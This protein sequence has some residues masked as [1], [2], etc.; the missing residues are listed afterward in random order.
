MSRLTKKLK[1]DSTENT[2]TEIRVH[3]D[4][5]DDTFAEKHY[6]FY[7]MTEKNTY[8]SK[9]YNP[10]Y[11]F[12]SKHKI[13]Y[14]KKIN[15]RYT[16][17]QEK[18][19]DNLLNEIEYIDFVKSCIENIFKHRKSRSETISILKG[20]YVYVKYLKENKIKISSIYEIES[21]QVLKMYRKFSVKKN[22]IVEDIRCTDRFF[23]E[24][25]IINKKFERLLTASNIVDTN[26]LSI[27]ALSSSVLYQLKHCATIEFESIKKEVLEKRKW[28]HDKDTLF[29]KKNLLY[30]YIKSYRKQIKGQVNLS[31]IILKKLLI[32]YNIDLY[33]A[34]FTVDF[35]NNLIQM[36]NLDASCID[37]SEKS[38]KNAL[39]WF[40]EFVPEYPHSKDISFKYNDFFNGIF[41]HLRRWLSRCFEI[42]TDKLD[43]GLFPTYVSVY[44]I[45]LIILIEQGVNSEV[46]SSLRV[47]KSSEGNYL[48]KGNDLG[49]CTSVEVVKNRSNKCFN[50]DFKN[51]SETKKNIDFF[52]EWCSPIYE[53]S[54]LDYL[55]QYMAMENKKKYVH[56]NRN[57]FLET[58]MKSSKSIFN[59]YEII[60]DEGRR[61]SSIDHRSIRKSHSYQDYLLAKT[62]FERQI[63]K[64]HNSSQITSEVYENFNAEWNEIKKNKIG[65]VQER[66]VAYFSGNIE[67]DDKDLRDIFEGPLADCRDNKNPTFNNAPKLKKNEYCTDWY[68]CL[69]QCDKS[70]V[71][72]KIHGPVIYAW[73]EFIE[74]QKNNFISENDWSKEYQIDYSA[75]INTISGFTEEEQS[76]CE[77]ESSKHR[78]FVSLKFTSIVKLKDVK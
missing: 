1:I 52:I 70:V 25:K 48:L 57:S 2:S 35:K 41:K 53:H 51:D 60:D 71:I 37:L 76:F 63:N 49:F 18:P 21:N 67:R 47:Y 30:T 27:P 9:K 15:P 4:N 38:E 19:E 75:A 11:Y 73:I 29:N 69:T 34:D 5:E 68:K 10:R 23:G 26:R 61:I 42:S 39:M 45:Y 16:Y 28:I 40:I 22:L 72:P 65:M 54:K 14:F 24:V 62:L 8:A 56:A 44:P 78:D 3:F 32:D 36:Y 33:D 58:V 77:K 20:L 50:L 13:E 55:F 17:I 64:N 43:E 74:E 59:K 7:L 6:G 66:L 46:L 31:G 12:S